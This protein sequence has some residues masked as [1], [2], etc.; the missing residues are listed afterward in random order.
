[1]MTFKEHWLKYRIACYPNGCSSQQEREC[2]QA[3]MSGALVI[4]GPIMEEVGALPTQLAC[5]VLAKITEDVLEEC[6]NHRD[7]TFVRAN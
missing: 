7:S 4:L 5:A 1:M 6:K 3:F 2:R